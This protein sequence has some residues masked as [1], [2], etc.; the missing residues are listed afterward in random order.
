M[1][2][3][4]FP[5]ELLPPRRRPAIAAAQ[6]RQ[7]HRGQIGGIV[8]HR[9]ARHDHPGLGEQRL[10]PRPRQRRRRQ[11]QPRLHPQPR[12]QP[13]IGQ[14]VFGSRPM[15]EFIAPG[16]IELAA[17]QAVGL[18]PRKQ[19]RL[20]SVRPIQLPQARNKGDVP[21]RRHP[22]QQSGFALDH[23]RPRRIEAG[24]HQGNAPPRY[25]AG[26]F[27][28][29][30][31]PGARLAEA[32]SCQDRPDRPVT[33]RRLLRGPQPRHA[34]DGK[35][36][37]RCIAAAHDPLSVGGIGGVP[38]FGDRCAGGA[39]RSAVCH[40]VRLHPLFMGSS[41]GAPSGA[42]CLDTGRHRLQ[43]RGIA[44]LRAG[45]RWRATPVLVRPC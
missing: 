38:D 13:Q 23:H 22:R 4:D 19:P 40:K 17:A 8:G 43:T 9:T 41:T 26:Q 35:I 6:R 16:K 31:R 28:H 20:R 32:A 14:R 44:R 34:A 1:V 2:F 45:R 11:Q 25:G 10:Q 18:A 42:T 37:M 39:G 7:E 5:V 12:R 29:P 24:R 3:D 36:D 27:M 21:P 30:F 15:R 33:I